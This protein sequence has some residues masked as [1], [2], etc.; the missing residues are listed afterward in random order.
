MDMQEKGPFCQSC[1]MPMHKPEDF[2]TEADGTRNNDYCSYCFQ[3]GAFTAPEMNVEQMIEFCT[4]VMDEQKIMP[5]EEASAML[6]EM[7]PKLK[8]WR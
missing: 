3:N 2:G 6:K 1:G 7:L 4:N 8:R 5:R